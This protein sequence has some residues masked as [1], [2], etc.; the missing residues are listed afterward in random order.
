MGEGA[1][2]SGSLQTVMICFVCDNFVEDKNGGAEL[3]FETLIQACP[4]EHFRMRAKDF[5][6][7]KA[8]TARIVVFSNIAD[9]NFSLLP[10]IQKE[11]NY[12]FIE[13]DYKYCVYRNPALHKQREGYDCDCD[14]KSYGRA[15]RDF[16]LG[17]K[18]LFWK[19]ES[20]RD[21]YYQMFPELK[22]NPSLIISC[23][24]RNEDLDR[25]LALRYKA[26]NSKYIIMDS[27]SW[28]K[29]VAAGVDYCKANGLKHKV[30]GGLDFK[31]FTEEM[32]GYKGLVFMPSGLDTCPRMVT[33]AK[34]MGLDLKINEKVQ[35]AQEEWFNKDVQ[36]IVAYLRERPVKFWEMVSAA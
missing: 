30:V 2:R 7:A 21:L 1:G 17:A 4:E 28:V 15:I 32:A 31:A 12:V 8:K 22:K 35:H 36:E 23:N 13:N 9:L 29:N 16:M 19:S 5:N 11:L 24:F 25:L 14:K 20:Q 18:M 10:I 34:I 6:L 33:E 3:S 26:K 27:D